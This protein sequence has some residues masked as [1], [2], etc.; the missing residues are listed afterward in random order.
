MNSDIT[1][2]LA[3]GGAEIGNL[4]RAIDE[5][6]A[7]AVLEAARTAGITLFDT[8][9]GYGKGL[10]E[11]RLGAFLRDHAGAGLRLSTKV[12]RRLVRGAQPG[13]REFF[14]AALPFAGLFDYTYDGVM[15]S[16]E[17]S[18]LRMG[19]TR[20][21]ELYV[22][23][24]DPGNHGEA[25]AGHYRDL[26]AG[27]L[28]ALAELRAAGDAGAIGVAANDAG[29]G[30]RMLAEGDWDVALLAARYTLLDQSALAAFLPTAGRRGV[31]VMA[32]GVFNSGIL[33]SG[34]GAGA[35]FDYRAAPAEVQARV[36][37]LQAICAGHDVALAGA[38]MQFAL[39]HPAIARVL[40]GTSRP[41]RIAET[42][43][44][45]ARPI[46]PGFW[47]DLRAAG[48]IPADAPLPVSA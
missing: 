41:A 6:E 16:F 45:L 25:L 21:D 36:A 11:L 3:F 19:V 34:A 37:A 30:A 48:A 32:G 17:E 40:V 22:H 7:R 14:A 12:G 18:M 44:A 29:F 9:P 26:M 28:R 43:A 1:R 10:G 20:C 2:R 42:V 31:R 15:R 27:G 24:L 4:H 39:A 35:R 13:A 38:A 47:A 8:A 23:D 46:P 33:A 5:A